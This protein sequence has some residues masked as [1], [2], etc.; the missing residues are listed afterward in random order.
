MSKSK[1]SRAE[2]ELLH[3]FYDTK[4]WICLRAPGSGSIPLPSPDLLAGNGKKHLAIECKATKKSAKYFPLQE[5]EDLKTF[6]RKFGAEPWIGL[7]FNNRDWYFL[8][9]EYLRKSG[10]MLVASLKFAEKEG[11]SFEQ[12]IE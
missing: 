2:R 1:G 10:K 7:R 6:A 12:L 9:P 8:K 11:L 3:K 5:I 4:K